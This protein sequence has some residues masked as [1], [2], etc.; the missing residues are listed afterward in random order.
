MCSNVALEGLG[1]WWQARHCA[2]IM[3]QSNPIIETLSGSAARDVLPA[4]AKLRVEVFRTFPYLYDGKE[5]DELVHLEVY[6]TQSQ[7]AIILARDGEQIIGAATCLPLSAASLHIQ[8]PFLDK[9]LTPS[10]FFYFGESVLLPVYRG[11]GLGVAFFQAREAH[12]SA[13]GHK[14]TCFCAV[15]RPSDHSLRPKDYHPLDAF[16][17]HR[18]YK[19]R[20]DLSCLMSWRDI[21][22][23]TTT[24]KR[25]V[26][27]MKSL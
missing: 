13:C 25:M 24:R 14:T 17:H 3:A 21:G 6:A 26:F 1:R 18:G 16:W 5:A 7:A 20:S 4:L 23:T 19:P 12:A 11:R 2:T 15:E 27:W 9:M 10:N 8:K 22:T